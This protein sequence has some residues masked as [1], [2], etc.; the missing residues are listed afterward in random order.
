MIS[1]HDMV[2]LEAESGVPWPDD[3]PWPSEFKD[4]QEPHAKMV[5]RWD[6]GFWGGVAITAFRCGFDRY[7]T[8]SF[9]RSLELHD[10]PPFSRHAT[11]ADAVLRVQRMLAAL[12]LRI[13]E[14]VH[15]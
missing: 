3:L 15:Q 10:E 7:L 5:W 2:R 9:G 6:L 13:A 14:R 11:A 12:K 4:E 8:C 1:L